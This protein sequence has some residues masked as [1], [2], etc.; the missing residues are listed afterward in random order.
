MRTCIKNKQPIWY[1]NEFDKIDEVDENGDFTGNTLIKYKDIKKTGLNLYPANGE[2]VEQIFG[3]EKNF[4]KVFVTVGEPFEVK[5]VFYIKEPITDD[6][7]Y[8]YDYIVARINRSLN[9]TYYALNRR[10]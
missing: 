5:T 7:I 1:S 9:N 3:T 2:I 8:N 10:T 4:D 6:D